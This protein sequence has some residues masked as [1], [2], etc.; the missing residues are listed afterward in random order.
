M[1]AFVP[2]DS[3][4]RTNEGTVVIRGALVV[5]LLTWGLLQI[6]MVILL[7]LKYIVQVQMEGRVSLGEMQKPLY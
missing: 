6:L 3:W 7:L 2:D 5:V 4:T 1:D